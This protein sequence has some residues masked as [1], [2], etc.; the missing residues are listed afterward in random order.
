MGGEDGRKRPCAGYTSRE[1]FKKR[2]GFGPENARP[3]EKKIP[4]Q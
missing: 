1:P 2:M 4:L 3:I